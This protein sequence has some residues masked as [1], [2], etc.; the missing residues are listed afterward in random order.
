MPLRA[1]S[2]AVEASAADVPDN[3]P[4]SSLFTSPLSRKIELQLAHEWRECWLVD[5]GVGSSR[6]DD[7]RGAVRQH[8]TATAATSPWRHSATTAGI[9]SDVCP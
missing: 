7:D 4:L 8:P 9:A 2:L 6:D 3:R 5:G 1:M